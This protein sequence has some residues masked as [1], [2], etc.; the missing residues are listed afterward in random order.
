MNTI[1]TVW[2]QH[3]ASESPL[4]GCHL[5]GRLRENHG[6]F[7]FKPKFKSKTKAGFD[8]QVIN[9]KFFFLLILPSTVYLFN[10]WKPTEV[11]YAQCPL[12]FFPRKSLLILKSTSHQYVSVHRPSSFA[13]CLLWCL[14]WVCAW[15]P[16]IIFCCRN[17][18]TITQWLTTDGETDWERSNNLTS[19]WLVGNLSCPVFTAPDPHSRK[20]KKRLAT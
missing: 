4:H 11:F 14:F 18:Y 3:K 17:H 7:L 5:V 8:Y 2:G 19:L 16:L 9:N 10:W 1:N 20:E 13:E 15:C 6:Y 12:F